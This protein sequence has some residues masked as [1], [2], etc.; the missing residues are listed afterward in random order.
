MPDQL[1]PTTLDTIARHFR[2][3][4]ALT[5]DLKALDIILQAAHALDDRAEEIRERARKAPRQTPDQNKPR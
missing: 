1:T 2:H 3:C 5:D 4:A